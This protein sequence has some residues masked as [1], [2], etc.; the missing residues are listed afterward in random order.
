MMPRSWEEFWLK[1][2]R[3]GDGVGK[4]AGGTGQGGESRQWLLLCLGHDEINSP[5]IHPN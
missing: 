4:V 1:S 3:L 5:I 2:E